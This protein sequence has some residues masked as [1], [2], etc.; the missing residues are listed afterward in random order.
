MTKDEGDPMAWNDL[1]NSDIEDD[2][3]YLIKRITC[4]YSLQKLERE[5]EGD[6]RNS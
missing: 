6:T 2:L 4:Y 3:L 1:Y 5:L